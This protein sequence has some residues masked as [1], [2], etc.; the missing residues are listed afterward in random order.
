MSYHCHCLLLRDL[1]VGGADWAGI[2]NL[3]RQ[4]MK[5]SADSDE[6]TVEYRVIA[7]SL[8]AIPKRD[9]EHAQKVF[10]VFATVAED[11][12]VPI[13]AFR[14]LLSAVTGEAGVE[15]TTREEQQVDGQ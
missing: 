10:R 5:A 11:T 8:S 3:L 13:S 9:R 12:H 15:A 2:P 7:A 14:I 4:E 6:T 1:G